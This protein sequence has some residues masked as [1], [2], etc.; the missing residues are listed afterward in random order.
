MAAGV[1]VFARM[2]VGAVV[3]AARGSTFLAGAQMNPPG[4]ELDALFAFA[5]AR[6]GDLKELPQMRT[7]RISNHWFSHIQKRLRRCASTFVP[8]TVSLYLG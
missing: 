6:G 5:P 2:L 8:Y 4:A 7:G 1:G 3:T